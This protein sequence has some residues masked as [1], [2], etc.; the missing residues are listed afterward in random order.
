MRNDFFFF[1]AS[2]AAPAF[3]KGVGCCQ[4]FYIIYECRPKQESC[5]L[6]YT[7]NVK[8]SRNKVTNIWASM[9]RHQSSL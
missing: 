2:R 4:A 5:W 7:V 8:G 9:Q 6:E 3:I 1:G